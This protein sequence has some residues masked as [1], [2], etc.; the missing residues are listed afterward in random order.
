ML[1]EHWIY[2]L[3]IAILVGMVYFKFTG[4]DYAWLVVASAYVPDM[5][6][7]AD[8]VLKK[9]GITVLLYGNPIRHGDFHNIAFLL[10]F[11]G[12]VAMVLHPLG[13]RLV[14]S[15][16]FAG[17]GFGAHLFEDALI[18]NPSYPFLWPLSMERFGIGIFNYTLDWHGIANTNVLFVGVMLVL[19]A[20]MLRTAHEGAGWVTRSMI[21]TSLILHL[22]KW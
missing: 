2:S 18:A 4:R 3:A 11:A 21:P 9:I 10:L 20:A 6:I 12:S 19:L 22:D 7:V 16:L 8:A 5:D 14:D 15:F 13:I 1:F 17:I